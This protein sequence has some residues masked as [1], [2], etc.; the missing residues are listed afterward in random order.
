M[1]HQLDMRAIQHPQDFTIND[2]QSFQNWLIREAYIRYVHYLSVTFRRLICPQ[3]Y[4][5]GFAV[6]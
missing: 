4:C 2:Y 3:H 6:R 5:N 1:I